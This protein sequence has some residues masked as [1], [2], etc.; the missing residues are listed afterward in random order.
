MSELRKGDYVLIQALDHR[1]HDRV[2]R[3][4]SDAPGKFMGTWSVDVDGV[5]YGLAPHELVKM[6]REG[7]GVGGPTPPDLTAE[8]YNEAMDALMARAATAPDYAIT[9]ILTVADSI[10]NKF[11]R[12]AEHHRT[13]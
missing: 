1:K 4:V 12:H 3:I 6:V 13:D 8:E 11:G 9:K 7:E 10:K 2:G 5:E